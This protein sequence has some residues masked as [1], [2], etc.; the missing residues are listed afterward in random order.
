MNKARTVL[1]TADASRPIPAAMPI[2]AVNQML[3]AVVS[4][5]TWPSS[6]FLRMAPAPRNPIPATRPCSTR[7]MSAASTPACWGMRT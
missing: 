7:V 1:R 4:P 2:A 5:S 3:A 6:A